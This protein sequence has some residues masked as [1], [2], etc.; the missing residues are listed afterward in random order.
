MN[1]YLL[2]HG[3]TNLN[4]DGKYQSAVDKDLNEFG[5]SQAEL[6]GQR[7]K[8]YNIEVIYS[9][10]LKRVVGT[11][12]II[13]KYINKEIIIKK[14]FREINMGEW[15]TLTIEERNISHKEYAKEW[16]KQIKD[17]PYPQGECGE[18]VSKRAM[19]IIDE[20]VEKE[21]ENVVI[22]TSGG[23]ISII[24]SHFL[25]LDQHKR[26]NM[27]ID[28]CSISIVKYNVINNKMNVNC[29]NDTG[30]LKELLTDIVS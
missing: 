25:G 10:D 8:S 2:R 19:K 22:S 17:M 7:L 11:S 24:I 5:I 21:Y 30:H 1:I 14:E 28:N 15:D 26:F 13:N 23:T 4:R 20:I 6:L 12:E 18:D 27:D 9:S 29:I 3:Q 16:S